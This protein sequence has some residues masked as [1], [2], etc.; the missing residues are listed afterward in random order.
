MRRHIP[1]LHSVQQDPGGNL[2]GFVPGP[3]RKSC[4][5]VAPAEVLLGLKVQHPGTGVLSV[6]LLLWTAVLY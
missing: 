2:D 3:R 6:T 5:S 4:L 1:G